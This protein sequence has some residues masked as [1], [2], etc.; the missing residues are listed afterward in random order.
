[1]MENPK[2]TQ[3]KSE[4]NLHRPISGFSLVELMAVVAIISL[5]TT[6]TIPRYKIFK[7]KAARVEMTLN[8][9]TLSALAHAYHAEHGHYPLKDDLSEIYFFSGDSCGTS[10]P[11]GFSITKCEKTTLS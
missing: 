10:N 1:M 9:Q 6:L 4:L 3:Q 5:L 7:I 11:L 2:I 8:T